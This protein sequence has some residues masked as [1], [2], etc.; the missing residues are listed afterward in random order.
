ME[1][2]RNVKNHRCHLTNI[3]CAYSLYWHSDR[4]WGHSLPM[5][6]PCLQVSLVDQDIKES[7]SHL[8]YS[9]LVVLAHGGL[10]M[11]IKLKMKFMIDIGNFCS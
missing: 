7:Q 3:Y 8:K 11:G 4:S 5:H 6:S 2:F 10:S 9:K 1:R